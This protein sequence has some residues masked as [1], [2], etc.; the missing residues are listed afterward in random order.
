MCD[1]S[2]MTSCVL[3][4]SGSPRLIT[5]ACRS[6]SSADCNSPPVLAEVLRACGGDRV[7]TAAPWPISVTLQTARAWPAVGVPLTFVVASLLTGLW[8]M[9][10][11]TQGA[12]ASRVH[13][14]AVRAGGWGWL[15]AG[16]GIGRGVVRL[17]AGLRDV[18]Q[19]LGDTQDIHHHLGAAGPVG[20]DGGVNGCASADGDAASRCTSAAAVCGH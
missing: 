1:C 5:A 3:L 15:R 6:L 12:V 16:T 7:A 4:N 20:A 8:G 13:V 9:E 2:S 18:P 11:R 10:H 14:G 19:N 17:P